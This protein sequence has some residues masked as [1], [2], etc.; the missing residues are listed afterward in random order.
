MGK[1]PRG[2]RTPAKEAARRARQAEIH[3]A[4]DAA[5]AAD[6][7]AN[8]RPSRAVRLDLGLPPEANDELPEAEPEGQQLGEAE[9]SGEEAATDAGWQPARLAWA[10]DL[11]AA[12][13]AEEEQ[14]EEGQP[15]EES[16]EAAGDLGEAEENEGCGGAAASSGAAAAAS[17]S[18]EAAAEDVSLSSEGVSVG[19]LDSVCDFSE[20]EQEEKV[21]EAYLIDICNNGSICGTVSRTN[22]SSQET[23]RESKQ[24]RSG[25]SSR[26]C[27][28][29]GSAATC[30]CSGHA[31]WGWH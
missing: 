6:L 26:T 28:S 18:G 22:R 29:G 10:A 15:Q 3:A 8:P 4:R 12:A 11:V 16:G 9:T 27:E 1:R 7:A 13:D 24:A 30:P 20:S 14:L 23:H 21:P 2:P 31:A 5:R 17:S 19:D 25:A